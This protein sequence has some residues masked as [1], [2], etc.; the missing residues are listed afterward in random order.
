MNE[1]A[2]GDYEDFH[3]AY[4]DEFTPEYVDPNGNKIWKEGWYTY[5]HR[6]AGEL[7]GFKSDAWDGG[8]KVPL[9]V[10]WPG[11]VPAGVWNE[12]SIC[13]ADILATLAELVG[14]ELNSSEGQ[15]SYS[16]LSN[17]RSVH[18]PQVR[19]SLILAGGSSGAMIALADNWKFIEAAD[20]GRWPETYY[21]NGPSKFDRQLY[22]L[23]DDASE[24]KNL[25]GSNPEKVNELK[26]I[27]MRVKSKTKTEGKTDI[28]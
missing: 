6:A 26:A 13:A 27:I 20:S 10:R 4:F 24:Q 28:D 9:I 11:Q 12:N 21:P 22:N 1:Y 18:A 15:D 7:L 3:Q 17:I 19:Q 5:D 8:L 25:Y 16:F 14:Y 23:A 2:N